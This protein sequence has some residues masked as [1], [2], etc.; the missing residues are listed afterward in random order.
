MR[1]N[2]VKALENIFN[3]TIASKQ[4]HE[5]VLFVEDASGNFSYKNGYGGRDLD[6]PLLMASITKLFTTTCILALQERGRLCLNDKVSDYFDDDI[7][8]S[9]HI[10]DGNE[11]SYELT[12][13]DLLFQISGLPDKFEEGNESVSSLSISK[14]SYI[15]FKEYVK[16]VKSLKP[17][18]VPRTEHKAFYANINFDMLGEIIE[19]VTNLP[20]ER[21]YKQLIFEPLGM[22]RTYLPTRE[23]DFIPNIYYK[24]KII[25]LPKT[26]ISSRASGGCI[27]TAHE[28]MI[29]IKAFFGGKLFSKSTFDELSIYNKL[30][31]SKGPI[32]YGGGYMQ[33]P[34]DGLTTFFMGK[35]ELIGHSGSTGSFAFYYP[36]KDLFIVGDVNQMANPAL[37]IRLI[38]KLAMMIK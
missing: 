13:S 7:M 38:I 5:C 26:V 31:V 17:H 19:K 12:I 20:L 24:D 9:L 35:G 2:R 4:I 23:E 21:A 22:T 8:S 25:H 33:I 37:P 11:Y 28:L 36:L 15:S 1:A 27:T 6:S 34:L 14:D 18:F 16:W 32:F 3:K 30:Q 29:F 10:Y